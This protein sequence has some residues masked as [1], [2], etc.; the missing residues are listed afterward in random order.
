MKIKTILILR[1]FYLGISILHHA[2]D[3][4]NFETIAVIIRQL[5]KDKEFEINREVGLYKWTPLYRA[6]KNQFLI[7]YKQKKTNGCPRKNGP[8]SILTISLSI[9]ITHT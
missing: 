3:S 1:L 6:G 4:K 2:I 9:F 5:N 8:L 7:K